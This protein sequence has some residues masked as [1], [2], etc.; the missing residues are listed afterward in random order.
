MQAAQHTDRYTTIDALRGIAALSVAFYHLAPPAFAGTSGPITSFL[1]SKFE[2]GYLGVPIFFV[3]SGFVITATINPQEVDFRYVGRFIA[4]RAI[5]LAPPYWVSLA[6]NIG[7]IYFAANVLHMSAAAVPSPTMVAAHLVYA[8]DL[9]GLGNISAIYYTLC[10]EV[11]F[12]IFLSLIF[13]VARKAGHATN[14]VIAAVGL[15]SIVTSMLIGGRVLRNPINGLF[16]SLWY[17]FALGGLC[18]WATAGGKDK[19]R[20]CVFLGYCACAFLLFVWQL[21]F[22]IGVALNT[23]AALAT[24]MFIYATATTDKLETWLSNKTLVYLGTI[25]Y[26]LYLFHP[27]FGDGFISAVQRF[28][29]PRLGV[30]DHSQTYSVVLLASAIGISILTAHAMYRLIER[31]SARFSKRIKPASRATS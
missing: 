24:A 17:L 25:S 30:T 18:Q 31:P 19:L 12:Y 15:A 21:R 26:S 22:G 8:Q 16:L 10:F 29:L 14:W 11:Q 2:F 20:S 1:Q 13:A 28:V 7:L 6:L 5:R 27:I 3:L 9:L 23:A 4:K